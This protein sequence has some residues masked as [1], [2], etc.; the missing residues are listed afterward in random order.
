MR[1]A[2][3]TDTN[4]VNGTNG[5]N[6][7]KDTNATNG[8]NGNHINN[9]VNGRTNGVNGMSGLALDVDG[10]AFSAGNAGLDYDV[11]IVGAGLS[12]IFSLHRMRQLGLR[13]RVLEAGSGEGGTWFWCVHLHDPGLSFALTLSGTAIPAHGLTRR[14]TPISSLLTSRSSTSGTG[15]SILPRSPRPS[16]TFST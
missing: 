16:A 8:E 3:T 10:K 15:Q 6:G 2:H 4:S 12:G 9:G 1:L 11:I 5:V 7:V 13:T 14:A